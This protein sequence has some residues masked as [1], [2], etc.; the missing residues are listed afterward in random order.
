LSRCRSYGYANSLRQPRV[1]DTARPQPGDASDGDA[2][3]P[4]GPAH[5][6]QGRRLVAAVEIGERLLPVA[7]GV[8]AAQVVR[9]RT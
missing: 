2:E 4:L 7:E 1:W 9:R 6:E 8:D 5:E 3:R